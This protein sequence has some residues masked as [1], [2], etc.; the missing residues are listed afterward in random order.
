MTLPMFAL[1]VLLSTAAAQQASV[2]PAGYVNFSGTCLKFSSDR[3]TYPDARDACQQEG[4][5]LVVIKTAALDNF[6]VDKMKNQYNYPAETWIGMDDL[7]TH[8][9]FVWDDGSVLS[10]GDYT[11]WSPGQPNVDPERCVEIRP[12]FSYM[13]NDH[14]C[15]ELKYYVCQKDIDVDECQSQPCQNGGQCIDGINRYDCQC[16]AGFAGT[17]CEL[18]IDEC[19]SQP[20]QNGGQCINGDNRYDCQCASGFAGTNCELNIDECQSQPCQN[21]GQCIDGDNR[22]DCQCA[23]GFAGTNCELNIDECQSQPCQNGGQCINGDNRYDCQCASGFAGTNCELMNYCANHQCQNGASCVNQPATNGYVC[24]CLSGWEGLRCET[25]SCQNTVSLCGNSPGWPDVSLCSESYVVSACPEFCGRCSCPTDPECKN[26]GS[27]GDDPN[28]FGDDTCDCVCVGSWSGPTCEACSLSCANGGVV[29]QRTCKCVCAD[30]WDGPTCSDVCADSNVLCGANPGWPTVESCTVE[31]VQEACHAFCGVCTVADILVETTPVPVIVN[32]PVPLG[33]CQAPVDLVFVIDGSGS[34]GAAEFEKVK[35]FMKNV[36]SGFNIGA[37]KTKV[38]VIQYSSSVKEE[39]SLNAHWT[40]TA[41]LNA[42]DNIVYMGGGTQTGTAI[43]YMKD[44]SQW[45]PNVAKIA[46][47]VT[48]GQSG[49]DVQ[50]PST[51]AQTAGITMHAIGV[52][53]NV[54]QTELSDIAST[55]QYVTTVADYDAL[56]AQMAQLTASVCDGASNECELPVLQYHTCV[57]EAL[58]T[59]YSQTGAREVSRARRSADTPITLRH[60]APV[61][62]RRGMLAV[63]T[64]TVGVVFVAALAFTFKMKQLTLGK[65]NGSA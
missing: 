28:L 4:A 13:W 57:Q 33:S 36:V 47:V 51:Q 34:V 38:G 59:C 11:H 64:V 31:Y 46:I 30:G 7:V 2:C 52:G 6:I 8:G 65:A 24:N 22:Y 50:V 26:G 20:C 29:D 49:D 56:A 60:Q 21:G 27:R 19:Q 5:H 45:R 62:N 1:L 9:Q 15:G 10:P 44:N 61:V 53:G 32:P 48:D 14:M 43:T 42:I 41:V 25:P 16:A 37:V 18:N 63:V 55:A 12:Q 35:A 58:S 23:S 17:N 40:N 3:K 39:F 54:D